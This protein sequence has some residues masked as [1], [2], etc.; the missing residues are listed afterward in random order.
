MSQ[1]IADAQRAYEAGQTALKS[2]DFAAY[3]VA[4]Q[5]LAAA[6]ARA[7][8]AASGAPPTASIEPVGVDPSPSP[9]ASG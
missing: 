1:A 2:G 8:A 4:Q 5:Q 9:S 7:A 6:L 3:G